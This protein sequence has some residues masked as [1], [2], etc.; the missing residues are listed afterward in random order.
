MPV[1]LSQWL[2]QVIRATAFFAPSA[3]GEGRAEPELDEVYPDVEVESKEIR[4][5]LGETQQLGSLGVGKITVA[6]APGRADFV[7]KVEE[8]EAPLQSQSL[9]DLKSALAIFLDPVCGWLSQQ[10]DVTRVAVGVHALLPAS[11]RDSAYAQMNE[12]LPEVNLDPKSSGE[13]IFQ[14]NRWFTL[15]VDGENIRCNRISR[16]ATIHNFVNQL[17]VVGGIPHPGPKIAESFSVTSQ[18]DFNSPAERTVPLKSADAVEL[19]RNLA[20]EATETLVN[21]KISQ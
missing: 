9:G 2:P 13:V 3:A 8:E 16:W 14:I 15:E 6:T 11:D 17:N 19:I 20:K 10:S 5:P 21:G 12:L 18:L 1:E 4:K 7:W